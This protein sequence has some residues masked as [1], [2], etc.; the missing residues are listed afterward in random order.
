MFHLA[1]TTDCSSV[2]LCNA[3]FTDIPLPYQPWS[4]IANNTVSILNLIHGLDICL[5]N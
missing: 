3:S 5:A 1:L 2:A 4:L